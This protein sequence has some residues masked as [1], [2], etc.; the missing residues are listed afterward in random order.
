[1][2]A[3][4]ASEDDTESGDHPMYLDSGDEHK[5]V[6]CDAGRGILLLLSVALPLGTWTL[7]FGAMGMGAEV[8]AALHSH[9]ELSDRTMELALVL[10]FFYYVLDVRHWHKHS[11]NYALLLLRQLVVAVAA[12]GMA[13][14]LVLSV[15]EYPMAPVAMLFLVGLPYCSLLYIT[16]YRQAT[17]HTFTDH[18]SK[19]LGVSGLFLMALWVQW[20]F[21]TGRH[22]DAVEQRRIMDELGCKGMLADGVTVDVASACYTSAH[23]LWLGPLL[24]AIVAAVFSAIMHVVTGV[25]SPAR[26][27]RASVELG[28]VFFFFFATISLLLWVALS[29]AAAG[30]RMANAIVLLT[31]CLVVE[32]GI[33]VGVIV[34]WDKVRAPVSRRAA[35]SNG[36]LAAWKSS[37]WVRACLLLAVVP[38]LPPLLLLSMLNQGVRRIT[39]V[40]LDEGDEKRLLTRTVSLQWVAV[41][42][43]WPWAEVLH[44]AC[45]VSLSVVIMIVGVL[46]GTSVVLSALNDYLKAFP[47]AQTVFIYMLVGLCMFLC[48]VV[49]GVP[50][51]VTGG[52]IVTSAA[53]PSMGFEAGMVLAMCV[54]WAVKMLSVWVQHAGIGMRCGQS[55]AIRQLVSINSVNTRAMRLTLEPPGLNLRKVCI[56]IGGPDWPTTVMTGILGLPVS[57]MLLGSTPVI[58]LIAPTVMAGAFLL[59][60]PTD[61]F[62]ASMQSVM[63]ASA[64]MVQAAALFAALYF[65]SDVARKR[66]GEI[67]AMPKDQ[68]VADA[69]EISARKAGLR[70]VAMDWRREGFPGYIKVS[71]HADARAAGLADGRTRHAQGFCHEYLLLSL[72]LAV[73]VAC[74][75]PSL[76]CLLQAILVTA[77]VLCAIPAYMVVG[78]PEECFIAFS[79]S[80]RIAD[81]LGGNVLNMI[82]DLGWVCL[83]MSLAGYALLKVFSAWVVCAIRRLPPVTTVPENPASCVTAANS[84]QKKMG[85]KVVV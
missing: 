44:A 48:P 40:N 13:V 65:V 4:A 66:E 27:T 59:K 1:M 35:A 6:G 28:R 77:T 41:R 29:I 30:S 34:G 25:V 43:A 61:A 46:N 76:S 83:S 74:S 70:A 68:Q 36:T 12:L 50:V 47:L 23:F 60:P 9:I 58:I 21:G 67:R 73:Q 42:E 56:L 52:I 57:Q 39:G 85:T 3:R 32:C 15:R 49:P 81:K 7:L 51:Y 38:V 71:A 5:D 2:P 17:I 37:K 63:L 31:L 10:I 19:A 22:W 54:G 64:S 82:L 24:F 45:L 75:R 33:S 62:A 11:S 84:S 26:D 14:A 78:A 53:E 79:V 18:L 20:I 72:L 69:D 55:V 80:D 16:V 8:N